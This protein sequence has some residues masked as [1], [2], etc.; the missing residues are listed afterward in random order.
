MQLGQNYSNY[1]SFW[2][3]MSA[4]LCIAHGERDNPCFNARVALKLK[5]LQ[6]QTY[7]TNRIFSASKDFNC[8]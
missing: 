8:E 6:L 3:D 7:L 2:N 5:Q 1:S 4:P